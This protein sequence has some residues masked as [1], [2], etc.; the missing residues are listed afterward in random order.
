[1]TRGSR[2]SRLQRVAPD[3]PT[4]VLGGALR[5]LLSRRLQRISCYCLCALGLI[6]LAADMVASDRPVLLWFHGELYVMPNLTRPAALRVF[7]NE[8]LVVAMDE[9][10]WAVFPPLPYGPNQHDLAAVLQAPS[11]THPCGTDV[12]GRDVLARIVHG[13]RVS[14][15]I[16]LLSVVVALSVGFVVGGLAGYYGGVLDAALMRVLE[17]VHALPLML[18]VVTLLAIW[19]PEGRSAFLSLTLVIG[20]SAWTGAARLLRVE[21]LRV[22]A[23]DYVMAARALGCS[24]LRIFLRHILPNAVTPLLVT[25]TFALPGAILLESTLSFLGFGVPPD[26]PSWGALIEDGRRHP[27]AWWL[28]LLPGLTV[29]FTVVACNYLGQGLRDVLD[30]HG[31]NGLSD[32]A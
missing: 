19:S 24:S 4:R 10:D 15:G 9:R 2:P 26:M 30:P 1:M 17:V 5:R 14:L 7:T 11:V 18:V 31:R 27:S 13:T 21:V 8:S 6:A 16:G 25:A 3:N 29:F 32:R 28:V 22:C 23:Q 20:L 12:L